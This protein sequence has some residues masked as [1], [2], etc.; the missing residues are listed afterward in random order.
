MTKRSN[1]EGTIYHRSNGAWQAQ[2]TLDGQRLSHTSQNRKE[3]QEWLK[4]TIQQVDQGLTL[5]GARTTL[6]Q[7]LDVWMSIKESKLRLSTQEQYGHMIR[8]YLKPQLGQVILKDLTAGKIQEFYSHLQ[9]KNIGQRTIEVTHTV[10]HGCLAHAHR[11]GLVIQN[12]TDLVEVPRPEKHEMRVWSEGQINQ[13]LSFSG[14]PADQIFYRLAFATGMRRGE[15]VGLKW[16]DLDWLAGT[17]K[18]R[19]QIYELA[20]GGFRFQEPKTARGQRSV[21]LGAGLLAALQIQY[22]QV[23]PLARAIAGARWKEYDLI[24]PSSIGTPRNGDNVS[25]QFQEYISLS[26]LPAIRFHDIR[27]SAASIMLLHGE[28]PVR[29]AGILGQSVAV[30]LGTYAHWIPDDQATAAALMDQVTSPVTIDLNGCSRVA[31]GKSL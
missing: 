28:P 9:K 16:E 17:I 12:S 22:N 24:F 2:I 20:G 8:M 26:G 6:G 1:G 5:N 3:C 11:L 29:V 30:L 25:R 21:R 31:A 4:Q 7:F 14:K 10:L 15:L 27:H 23:I 18:I 13:F 19:R